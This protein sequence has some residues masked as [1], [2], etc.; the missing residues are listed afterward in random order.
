MKNKEFDKIKEKAISVLRN[1]EIKKAGIFG[2]FAR[3]ESNSKSDVDILIEVKKDFSLL[4]LVKL[5][6]ELEK[7]LKKKV[8]LVEYKTI[9]PRLRKQIL[10]EEI[11]II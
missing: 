4:E 5:K 8:D 6:L 10:S 9:K 7:L 2:S 3:G 11:R 1:N